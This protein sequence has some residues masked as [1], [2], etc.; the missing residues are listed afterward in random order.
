MSKVIRV[1]G[2]VLFV[3]L[4]LI[5]SI[6][7]FSLVQSRL[8][9]G[10]PTLMGYRMFA[11]LSGSMNPAFNTGSL[12]AVKPIDPGELQVGDIITFGSP[13]GKIVT[14][15]VVGIDTHDGLRFVTKGD[16]NG[17]ADSG[18]VPA[19]RVIGLVVASVPWL[20]RILVFSQTRQGLLLMIIIPALVILILEA[21]SLWLNAAKLEKEQAEKEASKLDSGN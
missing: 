18:L 3:A 2:N 6:L 21:R 4:L 13:Q 10:P 20:G 1:F 17:A 16:A 9:G 12:V 5:L 8:T 15:R 14:H 11:V 7:V 19:D